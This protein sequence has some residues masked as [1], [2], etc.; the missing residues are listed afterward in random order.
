MRALVDGVQSG[1]QQVAAVSPGYKPGSNVPDGSAEIGP[2]LVFWSVGFFT[3]GCSSDF[4]RG[5][6]FFWRR[7]KWELT[8]Y[9]VR[10]GYFR[11]LGRAKA[12]FGIKT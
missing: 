9:Y 8:K 6:Y 2:A 4:E 12:S 3:V 11:L 1:G 10:T 7:Q 5:P